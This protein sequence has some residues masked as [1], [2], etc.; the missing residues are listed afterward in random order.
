MKK[1]FIITVCFLLKSI[2]IFAQLQ[3]N[4]VEHEVIADSEKGYYVL[5]SVLQGGIWF[6]KENKAERARRVIIPNQT[7]HEAKT[8]YPEDI[9]EYGFPN[10]IKYV[11]ATISFDGVEKKVFLEEMLNIDDAIIIYVYSTET[12]DDIFFILAGKENKLRMIN[13]NSPQEV[14]NIFKNQSD[15]SEIQGID[16]FPQKLTRKK[17]NVFHRAY[18]DC[19]SNLFPKF[20]FGPVANIGIG[21]PVLKETPTYS[22]AFTFTFSFGLFTQIPF[23]ECIALR[24]EILYLYLNNNKG[25]PFAMQSTNEIAKYNRHSITLP[26]LLRYTFNYNPWK[27][28]PYFELGPCFDYAFNGGKYRNGVL[29]K[30][31][32]YVILDEAT[33][34]PFQYGVSLGAG[35][36]HKISYK[37]SLYLGI[38]YNWVTGNRQEYV[39]KLK[40]LGINAA[41]SL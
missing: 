8:L 4:Q 9:E 32:R 16:D 40:F 12:N 35:I 19:N 23:D 7:N 37:K 25:N 21:K 1:I 13:S 17:I 14:W 15:C 38:R 22:Y 29:Q 26:L 27:N 18:K 34:I 24:T 6:L 30:P 36:D 10:G 28:I 5:N 31:D 3:S 33:I 2:V 41:I 11:S 39:E 20:Q